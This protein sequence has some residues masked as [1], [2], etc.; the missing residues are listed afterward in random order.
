MHRGN[1]V[2]ILSLKHICFDILNSTLFFKE[3]LHKTTHLHRKSR[4]NFPQLG[5]HGTVL[6][7]QNKVP[8]TTLWFTFHL[9]L[10]SLK[11][12]HNEILSR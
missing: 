10:F 6:F 9:L 2:E 5:S 4:P 8:G 7:C 1:E 11:T 12:T 3:K